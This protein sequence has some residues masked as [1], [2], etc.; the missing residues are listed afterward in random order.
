MA[1]SQKT[2]LRLRQLFNFIDQFIDHNRGIDIN[3]PDWCDRV[4]HAVAV[5]VFLC[6]F[7][8]PALLV[9]TMGAKNVIEFLQVFTICLAVQTIFFAMIAALVYVIIRARDALVERLANW[10]ENDLDLPFT[11]MLVRATPWLII[12]AHHLGRVGGK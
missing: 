12:L 11:T 8:L 6:L 5:I 9:A 2:A 4:V 7:S 10:I 1:L 3:E